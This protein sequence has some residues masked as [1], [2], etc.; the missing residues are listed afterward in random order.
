MIPASFLYKT[1]LFIL[2]AFIFLNSS[3]L[4]AQP[5][6]QTLHGL[7]S[8]LINAVMDDIFNPVVS[9]RIYTYPNIAFYE[10]IRQEDPSFPSL[11]GKLNGLAALPVAEKGTDYFIAASVAFSQVGQALIGSEYKMEDWRT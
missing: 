3:R 10:C 2:S 5:K 7:N 6:E 1:R 11:S 4:P 8:L 9:S